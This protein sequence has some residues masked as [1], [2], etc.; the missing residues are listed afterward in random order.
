MLLDTFDVTIREHLDDGFNN[1]VYAERTTLCLMETMRMKDKLAIEVSLV[2]HILE[3][4]EK[5]SSP[6]MLM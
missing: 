1:G 5:N 4:I 2:R 3:V 6:H